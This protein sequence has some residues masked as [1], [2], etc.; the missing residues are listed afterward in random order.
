MTLAE[1]YINSKKYSEPF[2]IVADEQTQGRGRKGNEWN[3]T[4]G[5]LWFNLVLDHISTQRSFTLFIGYCITKALNEL[6]AC[7]LFKLKWPND[8][9]L[10]SVKVCGIICSQYEQFHKTS[11][12]IGIDTNNYSEYLS[13]K[14]ILNKNIE[15]Q[16]YLDVIINNILSQL[17]NFEEKGIDFFINYYKNHDFL[18][19]KEI[20]V[21][22][23]NENFFGDYVGI[24]PDGALLININGDIKA[25]YSGTLI[26]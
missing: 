6:N 23:G 5:G 26:N 24:N 8:I 10:N 1:E 20:T 18:N 16:L 11:I 3:S 4:L 14:Q 7:N 25:I 22:S 19:E 9:Y 15:N 13:I 12:G 2:L 21:I 17:N